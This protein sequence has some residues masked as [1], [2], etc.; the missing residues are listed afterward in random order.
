M[1]ERSQPAAPAGGAPQPGDV[2]ELTVHE[3]GYGGVG[4]ARHATGLVCLV[5]RTLPGEH[6]EATI[7]QRKARL[8]QARVQRIVQPSPLRVQ[9][10][11]THFA[12]CGGCHLQHLGYADQLRAKHAVLCRDVRRGLGDVVADL[13]APVEPSPDPLGY[14]NRV[15]HHVASGRI[16]FVDSTD[17]GLVTIAACAVAEPAVQEVTDRVRAWLVGTGRVWA[18]DLLDLLVR[19]GPEGALCVLVTAAEFESAASLRRVA[20]GQRGPRLDA[21]RDLVSALAPA[22]LFVSPK[23]RHR[24][25]MFGDAFVHLGGATHVV[26]EILGLRLH[27]SPGSFAQANSA[28]ASALYARAVELLAPAPAADVLDL[29]SGSGALALH[30]A[31]G[32]GR[33]IAV[34]C[35]ADAVADARANATRN[36]IMN[37]DWRVGRSEDAVDELV[38]QGAGV[39]YVSVN[40][41]R[42]GL[43]PQIPGALARLA[44]RRVVYLSCAPP[45]LLRDLGRLQAVGYRV[46]AMQPFD[47]FP[48]THHLEIV[49]LLERQA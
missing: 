5:P 39:A 44:P 33:V 16:G 28:V 8:A 13:V 32:G 10:P 30:L 37:V 48:Q 25:T 40:P 14:R 20:V 1:T 34:E 11:C 27:L 35:N 45:S 22:S 21:L 36:G 7:V 3:L 23:P 47:M 43:A 9:A 49:T 26:Q 15:F 12:E 42:A 38:R 17:G 29:Y 2:V 46:T 4:V 41:P 6:I 19:S 31:R 18:D 24:R